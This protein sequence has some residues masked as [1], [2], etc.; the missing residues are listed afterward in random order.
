MALSNQSVF[1]GEPRKF[2]SRR[3]VK[4]IQDVTQA[5]FYSIWP[6]SA[7]PNSGLREEV[8]AAQGFSRNLFA[9]LVC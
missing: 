4:C 5:A 6:S 8:G 9:V 3:N 7:K 2:E 1:Y